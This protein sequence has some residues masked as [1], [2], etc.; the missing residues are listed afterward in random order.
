[1]AIALTRAVLPSILVQEYGRSVYL[2]LGCADCIRGL[3]AF[4][5]CPLFGKLSDVWGRKPCLLITVIGTCAPACSLAFFAWQDE[6]LLVDGD[7]L[8]LGSAATN[9]TLSSSPHQSI[10]YT[11]PPSAI[12]LFMV[13]LSLSGIFSSTF[14]L[15]FAYISDSVQEKQE[16]VSA[17]GLALA[18]FGLSFTIG[19]MAGGYL[20]D[21]GNTHHVFRCSLLLTI[22]DVLYIVLILP[23]SKKNIGREDNAVRSFFRQLTWSTPWEGVALILRDPFLRIVGQVA[24]LYYTGL[25]AVISTLSLYAVQHFHL[26][27]QRLGELMSL[28]GLSTMIAEA[29]LVRILVPLLGERKS[30]QLGLL[31]FAGQC[32]VLGLASEPWY[33]FVC[34]A[35]M[36][37]LFHVGQSRLSI[38]Q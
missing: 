31:S 22:L 5:A 14:T 8:L 16:R 21:S 27:P 35:K 29:V 18:T 6:T 19:P 12:P 28:L 4:F 1:L 9:A 34:V 17:Y 24:L 23:E 30:I 3:L 33:L 32:L 20:A 10:H 15:V 25:W 2:V 36:R 38:A 13:F 11:F 26:T 7:R 37:R